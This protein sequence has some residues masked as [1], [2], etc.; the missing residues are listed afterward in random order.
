MASAGAQPDAAAL[1]GLW[2]PGYL[3]IRVPG[4]SRISGALA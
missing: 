4:G 2:L 1:L 3:V